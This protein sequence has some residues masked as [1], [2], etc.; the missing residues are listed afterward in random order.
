MQT[1]M[2]RSCSIG[3]YICMPI[4]RKIPNGARRRACP[5]NGAPR[6]PSR[7]WPSRCSHVPLRNASEGCMGDGRYGL[8]RRYQTAQLARRAPAALRPGRA[9]ERAALGLPTA[10]MRSWRVGLPRGGSACRQEKAVKG[11]GSTIEPGSPWTSAGP[12]PGGSSGCSPGAVSLIP[13]RSPITLS[14]PRSQSPWSR[15]YKQLAVGGRWKKPLSWLNSRLDWMTMKCVI[16]RAGI[17]ISPW[18]CLPWPF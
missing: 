15:W 6:Y 12:S 2:E 1:D 3:N 5:R 14:L 9:N 13:Q 8:W 18:R 4:G 16:G 10:P 11:H 17:G 7:R